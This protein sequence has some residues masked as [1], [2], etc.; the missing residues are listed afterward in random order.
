MVAMTFN[1]GTLTAFII[2]VDQMLVGLGYSNSGQVTSTT[3]IS[4][5]IVGILSNG[6]FSY[7]L[8]KTKAYRAVSALSNSLIIQTLLEDF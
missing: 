5:M 4:A 2:I 6:I 3:I 8:R 1:Y 7:L